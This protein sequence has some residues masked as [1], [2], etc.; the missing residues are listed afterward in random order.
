MKIVNLS[1][2]NSLLN[3]YISEI[4]DVNVQTDSL[5]FRRNIERIGEIMA[6][7]ISKSIHYEN[8]EV[9]TPLGIAPA[10]KITDKI[11]LGTILR[12]GLGF[13]HGFLNYF[14]KAENAFVSAYRKYKET[15]QSFNISIEY[16]SSPNLEGKTLIL[17]DPMLAT[18]SSMEL[19]YQALTTKGKPASIHI[20]SIIS[21]QYAI[22]FC[23]KHFPDAITTIWTAAIDP[24]LDEN[25]Y[26]VPGLG[27][28]GDLA[29]GEKI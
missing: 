5:R 16:I 26:I 22:D 1:E 13:H 3:I 23:E 20:A 18:G 27:D 19:S 28:A 24:E 11:V 12:A 2:Q 25:S 21:S 4:R 29:Y 10:K 7:E 8:Y 6:Y 9:Q 15:H 14:D 17:T